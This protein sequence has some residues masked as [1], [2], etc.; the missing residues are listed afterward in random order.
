MNRSK[1]VVLR[2]GVSVPEDAYV[3]SVRLSMRGLVLTHE[4]DHLIVEPASLLTD[5]DRRAIRA[6]KA[7]LCVLADYI[8]PEIVQ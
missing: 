2:G 3:L 7:H 5:V 6:L 1:H 4:G 8:A